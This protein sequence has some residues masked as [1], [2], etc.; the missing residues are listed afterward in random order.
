M[1]NELKQISSCQCEQL[2]KCHGAFFQE[3][4]VR[5]LFEYMDLSCLET[6]INVLIWA[7][8]QQGAALQ[9][10][11][12]P[13]LVISKLVFQILQG[14]DYLHSNKKQL[15][16]DLKPGNILVNTL[17]QAKISDFGIS[18]EFDKNE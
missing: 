4:S 10:P 18:K 9:A 6:L 12:V 8:N 17:G 15:H 2:L 13:E 5:L 1:Y 7:V 14:L 16:R 11:L 3:G